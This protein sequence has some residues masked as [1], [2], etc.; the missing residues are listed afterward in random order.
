MHDQLCPQH[1][2]PD[3]ASTTPDA[4]RSWTNGYDL[5]DRLITADNANGTAVDQ[6]Y[7]YDD[8]DNMI[9]NTGLCAAQPDRRTPHRRATAVARFNAFFTSVTK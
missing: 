5:L 7:A 8:A 3:T 2:G 1:Q 9:Y 6:T 4:T